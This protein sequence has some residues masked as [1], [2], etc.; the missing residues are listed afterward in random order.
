VIEWLN[1]T[2]AAWSALV[3]GLAA[4][5]TFFGLP[6]L[7][8]AR[9]LG[10]PRERSLLLLVA[11]AAFLLPASWLVARVA[12]SPVSVVLR[13]DPGQ[14]GLHWPAMVMLVHALGIAVVGLR[15]SAPR[16]PPRRA[17]SRSAACRR[18]WR[19]TSRRRS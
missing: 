3:L 2:G 14:A 13:G 16:P 17:C 7:A 11:L 1:V 12:P 5:G 15:T 6:A 19:R 9:R 4:Q 10:H 8:L 18:C